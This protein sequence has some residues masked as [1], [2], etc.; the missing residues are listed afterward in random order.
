M[1]LLKNSKFSGGGVNSKVFLLSVSALLAFAPIALVGATDV[2]GNEITV[3]DGNTYKFWYSPTKAEDVAM[4][5]TSEMTTA[6]S[7][8]DAVF[9]SVMTTLGGW[10]YST[11][12][13]V[14][15]MF[16]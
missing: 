1:K 5:N 16:R 15:M 13:G 14:M 11:K 12:V 8:F 9:K 6:G 2:Y 3:V 10:L 4:A 7:R